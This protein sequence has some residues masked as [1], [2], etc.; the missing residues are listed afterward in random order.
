M[1]GK[2]EW[3]NKT[4]LRICSSCYS[5]LKIVKFNFKISNAK[6]MMIKKFHMEFKSFARTFWYKQSGRKLLSHDGSFLRLFL[7]LSKLF[8]KLIATYKMVQKLFH[9]TYDYVTIVF[10]V[11]IFVANITQRDYIRNYERTTKN[12]IIQYYKETQ[13]KIIL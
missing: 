3:N 2:C 8:K 6:Q 9:I 10:R 5:I 7:C 11:S 4:V 13:I 12:K 1:D